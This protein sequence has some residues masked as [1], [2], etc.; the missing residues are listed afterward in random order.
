MT[1]PSVANPEGRVS[2]QSVLVDASGLSPR[3]ELEFLLSVFNGLDDP[4]VFSPGDIEGSAMHVGTSIWLEPPI[5]RAELEVAPLETANLVLLQRLP[6]DV[7]QRLQVQ[8][9][10]Q[11]DLPTSNLREAF[12]WSRVKIHFTHQGKTHLLRIPRLILVSFALS[13]A[14]RW[15]A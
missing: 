3:G 2:H 8:F 13:V 5:L 14:L 15:D 6:G 7:S 4:I 9:R 1:L 12:E 11:M 10:R